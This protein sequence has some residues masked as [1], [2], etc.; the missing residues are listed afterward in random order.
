[1]LGLFVNIY[2]YIYAR[3]H[4]HDLLARP[5]FVVSALFLDALLINLLLT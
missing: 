5:R 4:T 3:A 1:M 2:I